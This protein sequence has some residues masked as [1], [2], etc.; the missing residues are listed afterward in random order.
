MKVISVFFSQNAISKNSGPLTLLVPFLLSTTV[1]F[2]L[3]DKVRYVVLNTNVFLKFC[4]FNLF[5]FLYMITLCGLTYIFEKDKK[6]SLEVPLHFS[7]YLLFPVYYRI[8]KIA[9]LPPSMA[10]EVCFVHSI[11]LSLK[12]FGLYFVS[13]RAIGLVLVSMVVRRWL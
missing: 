5:V 1:W 10:L 4:E 11:L 8:L 9:G 7:P 3:I 13:Y 6:K 12:R 2:G